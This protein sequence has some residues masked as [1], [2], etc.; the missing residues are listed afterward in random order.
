[1]NA[2]ATQNALAPGT[3]IRVQTTALMAVDYHMPFIHSVMGPN[4][5]CVQ[6]SGYNHIECYGIHPME[7]YKM[8]RVDLLACK[9][10]KLT[11]ALRIILA[12][13]DTR[14]LNHCLSLLTHVQTHVVNAHMQ[15]QVAQLVR[16]KCFTLQRLWPSE[17]RYRMQVLHC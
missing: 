6:D 11:Q 4:T 16:D 13:T 2:K 9:L 8:L 12:Q 14:T 17:H 5:Q 3:T 7:L 10:S 15:L 1:M